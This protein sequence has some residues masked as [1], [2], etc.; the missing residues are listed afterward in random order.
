LTAMA[1]IR[2]LVDGVT[3]GVG[4]VVSL[5]RL[6]LRRRGGRAPLLEAHTLREMFVRC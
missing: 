4:S 2:W 1:V 5:G 3:V 6:L